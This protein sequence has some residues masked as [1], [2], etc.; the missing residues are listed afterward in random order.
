MLDLFVF[1]GSGFGKTKKL[2]I[3]IFVK[4]SFLGAPLHHS[5]V[6]PRSVHVS[7]PLGRLFHFREL[8]SD[9]GLFNEASIRFQKRFRDSFQS[10]FVCQ[11]LVELHLELQNAQPK[12]RV[13]KQPVNNTW[14][15]L[16]YSL[17]FANPGLSKCFE[18]IQADF[19][20]FGYESLAPKLSWKRSYRNLRE[21]CSSMIV[22]S[23]EPDQA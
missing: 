1:K 15:V 11:R 13:A 14:L 3:S 20:D 9:R 22:N 12:L 2:D 16:P 23:I 10:E 21:I 6:H 4:P 5:S 18:Q 8:C 19:R 7:W 17:S